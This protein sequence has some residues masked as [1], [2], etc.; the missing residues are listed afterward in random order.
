MM[1]VIRTQE[2][3]CQRISFQ[4]F[5]SFT[6]QQVFFRLRLSQFQKMQIPFPPIGVNNS[7]GF[8]QVGIMNPGVDGFQ[9][10]LGVWVKR[11][12][13]VGICWLRVI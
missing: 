8:F 7:P 13:P 11:L 3:I 12:K 4:P 6:V 10:L 9:V 5:I 1:V 2:N